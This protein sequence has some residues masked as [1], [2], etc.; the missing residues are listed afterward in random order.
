MRLPQRLRLFHLLDR[1][2]FACIPTIVEIAQGFHGAI[3]PIQQFQ[4]FFA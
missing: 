4:M 1:G 2:P 3:G